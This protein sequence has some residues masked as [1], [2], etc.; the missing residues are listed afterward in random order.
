MFSFLQVGPLEVL[1]V[2][3]I[4]G[5]ALGFA[6]RRHSLVARWLLASTLAFVL[7]ALCTPA[8]PASTWIVATLTCAVFAAGVFL[9]P[10]FGL[11]SQTRELVEGP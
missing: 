11:S 7:A 3:L 5:V 6:V 8:D 1:T 2:L 4:G 10:Y 9:A